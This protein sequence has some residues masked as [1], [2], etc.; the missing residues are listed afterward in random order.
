MDELRI[1][2]RPYASAGHSSSSI[3]YVSRRLF[4]RV[5]V[6]LGTLPASARATAASMLR[7]LDRLRERA[8][9][10]DAT[11]AAA[12]IV[13][14]QFRRDLI[15][16]GTVASLRMLDGDIQ[17]GSVVNTV[18]ATDYVDRVF[19]P[20]LIPS[21]MSAKSFLRLA[22]DTF[23]IEEM[24][25]ALQ[26]ALLNYVK[27]VPKTT[28]HAGNLSFSSTHF[29][30]ILG[31]NL[32]HL[33]SEDATRLVRAAIPLVKRNF[34]RQFTKRELTELA[35]PRPSVTHTLRAVVRA[36]RRRTPN[37]SKL[38]YVVCV[39]AVALA[40]EEGILTREPVYRK[41]YRSSN[42]SRF[43]GLRD[44]KTIVREVVAGEDGEEEEE[45]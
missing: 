36:L 19:R 12:N 14:L 15:E 26:K 3:L 42:L 43:V 18:T 30:L 10:E 37:N 29:T 17:D 16:N 32:S 28:I 5:W 34:E 7:F 44:V 33:S 4:E 31:G 41:V 9:T 2:L 45:E 22:I 1:D 6:P 20:G 40:K 27:V 24:K 38:L 11:E 39:A 23:T 25:P 8:S 13:V 21:E 35:S